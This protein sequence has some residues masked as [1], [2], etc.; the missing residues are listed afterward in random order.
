M[1]A[2]RAFT[3]WGESI[4]DSFVGVVLMYMSFRPLEMSMSDIVPIIAPGG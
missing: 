3:I 1:T 2:C 4:A